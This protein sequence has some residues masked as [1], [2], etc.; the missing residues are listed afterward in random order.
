VRAFVDF[1]VERLNIDADYMRVMCEDSERC[2]HLAA[3][4]VAVEGAAAAELERLRPPPSG[5]KPAKTRNEPA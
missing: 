5:A 3:A 2:Q 4:A 1:L